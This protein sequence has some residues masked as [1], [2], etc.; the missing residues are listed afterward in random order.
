MHAANHA[1]WRCTQDRIARCPAAALYRPGSAC[2]PNSHRKAG[3][4]TIVQTP[5]QEQEPGFV[6]TPGGGEGRRAGG[7]AGANELQG[8]GG[9]AAL[10]ASAALLLS[11]A[12]RGFVRL[13]LRPGVAVAMAL[14]ATEAAAAVP[15]TAGPQP[16]GNLV[17]SDARALAPE[18]DLPE[19]R[20]GTQGNGAGAGKVGSSCPWLDQLGKL[21]DTCWAGVGRQGMPRQGAAGGVRAGAGDLAPMGAGANAFSAGAAEAAAAA[22][23]AAAAAAAAAEVGVLRLLDGEAAGVPYCKAAWRAFGNGCMQVRCPLDCVHCVAAASDGSYRYSYKPQR[24]TSRELWG[25]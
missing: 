25:P 21:L 18:G 17:T 22:D 20:A 10:P 9:P 1:V 5:W 8:G 12:D 15:L 13:G 4:G 3:A 2:W 19:G 16:W 7:G 14:R 24:G 23:A 11:R 6:A